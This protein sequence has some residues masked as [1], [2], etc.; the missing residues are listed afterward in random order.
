MIA[1]VSLTRLGKKR[2]AVL[3]QD[4]SWTCRGDAQPADVLN[5]AFNP[6]DTHQGP[7]SGF[8]GIAQVYKAVEEY[9]GRVVWQ[10]ERVEV[11]ERQY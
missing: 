5:I 11:P 2:Y 6:N 4:G 3:H 1:L 9:S 8:F 10:L 7:P